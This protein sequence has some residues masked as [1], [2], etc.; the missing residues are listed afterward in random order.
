MKIIGRILI[1][2]VVAMAIVGA[3]FAFS[4]TSAAAQLGG[5]GEHGAERF[6]GEA[7]PDNFDRS[8]FAGGRPERG[9]GERDGRNPSHENG[10]LFNLAG[11]LK[12]LV[13]IS[14]IVLAITLIDTL[15]G[16]RRKK[17]TT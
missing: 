16:R 10:S 13:I 8:Q 2:L 6:P 12:N 14:V 7:L 15:A 1:I 4:H 9:F 3:A 5:G 11:L 17:A